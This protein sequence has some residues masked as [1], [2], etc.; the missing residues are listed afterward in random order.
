MR[1]VGT[2][3]AFVFG[4]ILFASGSANAQGF[5]YSH[6]SVTVGGNGFGIHIEEGS[7]GSS[8][9][10]YINNGRRGGPN[11]GVQIQNGHRHNRGPIY[12]QPNRNRCCQQ[13]QQI[14]TIQIQV[15]EVVQ[16]QREIVVYDRNGYPCY[17]GRY[18]WVNE[19]VWVTKTAYW[20]PY[21]GAYVYNDRNGRPCV[22]NGGGQR[23]NNGGGRWRN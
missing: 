3:F 17:T 14:Q 1:K 22:W 8:F 20:D 13:Q 21:Q 23:W 19:E 5:S 12:Q 6:S 10:V 11:I 7:Y 4:L 15:L 18:Q 2:I 9:G 16:V